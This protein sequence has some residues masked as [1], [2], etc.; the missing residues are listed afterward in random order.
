MASDADKPPA[1]TRAAA[2]GHKITPKDVAAVTAI[3][4]A[5]RLGVGRHRGR[6]GAAAGAAAAATPRRSAGHASLMTALLVVG[7]MVGMLAVMIVFSR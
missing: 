4:S 5:T 2:G 3:G 1:G 6:S 7:I